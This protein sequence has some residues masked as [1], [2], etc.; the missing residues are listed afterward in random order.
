MLL[1]SGNHIAAVNLAV[2]WKLNS[3]TQQAIICVVYTVYKC[4]I[5]VK[6]F[7]VKPLDLDGGI[8]IVRAV[9]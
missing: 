8:C 2:N 3:E 1:F 4:D 6:H 9:D 7:G 5:K